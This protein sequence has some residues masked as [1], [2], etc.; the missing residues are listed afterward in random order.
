ML[1]ALQ[2][3]EPETSDGAPIPSPIKTILKNHGMSPES[4]NSNINIYTEILFQFVF[5]ENLAENIWKLH[6][7]ININ[8]KK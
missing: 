7:V 6:N 3:S 5:G 1:Q 2:E 8:S 4:P